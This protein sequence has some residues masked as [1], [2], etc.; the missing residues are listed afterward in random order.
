MFDTIPST[1]EDFLHLA[2]DGNLVPIVKHIPADLLTPVLA[3][4]KIEKTSP[5]AFLLESVEG[6]ENIARYSFIGRGPHQILRSRDGNVEQIIGDEV[7]IRTEP[8]LNVLRELSD[9][10]WPVRPSNL[11]PFTGGAVGYLGYDAVRWFER[12]PDKNPNDLGLDDAVMMFFN[13]ILVFDH[14]KHQ[15]SIIANVY[16][17]NKTT[18]LEEEYRQAL[19]EIDSLHVLLTQ[20]YEIEMPVTPPDSISARSNMSQE[21]FETA[22]SI[23]KDYI[24]AGDAFQIVLSQR[25]ETKL[26]THPFRIY[27]ALRMVNPSP[28]MFFLKMDEVTVLGAS[29]EMLVKCTGRRLEYRPIAGTQPRGK[30]DEDDQRLEQELLIDEKECAEHIMLVD[31]GRNDLGRVSEYGSVR[32]ENMMFVERYSHV[33]HM[34]SALSGQLREGLD[35]FDALAACFPAGTLTGAPKVRAMEII[36]ELEPTR[37][38][39]YGGAVMYLDYAGNLDSCIAIRTMVV[40]NGKAYIQAGAGIVYDSV[41]EREHAECRN[42]AMALVRAIEIA[43]QEL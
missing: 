12:I 15:I 33:M 23:A 35:R 3:Y 43:E 18:D 36:D 9:A 22:V 6:G 39:V 32:V 37:R 21:E 26:T 27:R 24:T 13:S 16:T 7:T 40:K 42:K 38:G 2:H 30:T 28:Y 10:Y 34:V 17:H 11:P 1:Y 8:Y 20:P 5:Y 41:P 4:L 29:P 14:V 19:K 31:L 25:L